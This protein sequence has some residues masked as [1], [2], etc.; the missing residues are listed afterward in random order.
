LF[1]FQLCFPCLSFHVCLIIFFYFIFCFMFIILGRFQ[2]F[3]SICSGFQSLFANCVKTFVVIIG[4]KSCCWLGSFFKR[5]KGCSCIFDFWSK[6]LNN[7]AI[8]DCFLNWILV[9][10]VHIL[11]SYMDGE[12]VFYIQCIY[13]INKLIIFFHVLEVYFCYL[14][15]W[16]EFIFHIS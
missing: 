6:R 15:L 4:R 10:E 16:V 1:L 2:L 7:F 8:C 5:N 12:I 9:L 11:N 13:E 3:I 14:L